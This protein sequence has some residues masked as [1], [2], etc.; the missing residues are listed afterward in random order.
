METK[1]SIVV[2]VYNAEKTLIKCIESILRLDCNDYEIIF[3]D[4]GST[5]NS[6]NIINS[7]AER[8]EEIRLF[9]QENNGPASARNRGIKNSSGDIIFFTDSDVVVPVD[10]IKGMVHYFGDK[11]LGAVGGGIT[12]YSMNTLSEKFEQHRRERLYGNEKK[13]VD[14]LPACNLAVKKTILDEI[15]YFDE[16]FK[17]AS[18][19][20][21]D[22]CYRLIDKGYKILYDPAISV[23]HFHS[24]TWNGVFRRGYIHGRE[25][26]K[27]RRKMGISTVRE[28]VGLG[29]LLLLPIFVFKNYPFSFVLFGFVYDLNVYFGR[30]T[31]ILKYW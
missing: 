25:G 31:G 10:W 9:E 17:F 3:V 28:L 5:D 29:G 23:I 2:P 24:Q 4:D 13:F 1:I 19:E 14:A 6:K 20:D 16:S 8:H 30:A 18:S 7:F 15:D 27:L 21:Y 11:K 26:V 12:P 22:L